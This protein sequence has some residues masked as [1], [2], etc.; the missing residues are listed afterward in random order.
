M[1]QIYITEKKKFCRY[2]RY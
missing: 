2:P 1:Y